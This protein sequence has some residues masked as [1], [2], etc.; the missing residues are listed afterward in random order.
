MT[1][2]GIRYFD[3]P[4]YPKG[5]I[6]TAQYLRNNMTK[7]ERKVWQYIRKEQ[8][9]VRFRR[10]V[11]IGK[12]IV[13]FFALNIGL[14]IEIDGGQHYDK[15]VAKKDEEISDALNNSGLTVVR[16]NNY[17]VLTNIE[18]VIES[19]GQMVDKLNKKMQS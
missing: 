19:I 14:V 2:K 9:G 3:L 5:A 18:A 12:Y 4:S 16:Y 11:P 10:Q 8:L 6:K 15:D 1:K 13:D 17:E 7:A